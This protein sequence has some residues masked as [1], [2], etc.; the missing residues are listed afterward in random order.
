MG[1]GWIDSHAHVATEKYFE[2]FNAMKQEALE[3]GIEKINIICGDLKELEYALQNCEGDPMFD[4]SL[5]VHPM[6]VQDISQED[7]DTML[8]YYEH[9]QV[10]CVGEIGLDYYWD[11]THKDLQIERLIQ[12]IERANACELPIAVHIRN[13]K[14]GSGAVEDVLDII[15]KHP[16]NQKGVIHCYSDTVENA[17]IFL[18]M[19]FYLG[20]GGIVTFKNGQNVRDALAVTPI[21]R[22]L[23]ETDSPFLAPVPKRGKS[24]QPAYVAYVGKALNNH[25]GKDMREQLHQNYHRLYKKS[26]KNTITE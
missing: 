5:G 1:F 14:E 21:D 25:F 7:F 8:T 9:P 6:E 11:K 26:Q 12:Q 16:V 3:H 4:I 2:N 23:S 20:Y 10:V 22:V 19:G 13:E 24:N 15:A 17:K 18:D